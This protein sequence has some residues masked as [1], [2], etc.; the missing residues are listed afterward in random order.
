MTRT[1]AP[2]VQWH[3]S[4][5]ADGTVRHRLYVDGV[6]T[7]Y[8]V[9]DAKRAGKGHF[10]YGEPVGLHAS[11]MGAVIRRHDGSTYQIA[12]TFGG[13]RNIGFAKAR[14]EQLALAEG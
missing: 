13:F 4:D 11:G 8:F 5:F 12:A 3:R 10:T 7:P 2:A 14:A 9:D 6:E 1:N